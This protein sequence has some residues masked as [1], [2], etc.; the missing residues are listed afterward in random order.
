MAT[1]KRT[2]RRTAHQQPLSIPP[3]PHVRGLQHVEG[4]FLQVLLRKFDLSRCCSTSLGARLEV[5]IPLTAEAIWSN[6]GK[7]HLQDHLPGR[8]RSN[9]RRIQSELR[10]VLLNRQVGHWTFDESHTKLRFR[11]ASGG[12]L[13]IVYLSGKHYYCLLYREIEPIGWN[14][15]NGGSDSRAELLSPLSTAERELREELLVFDFKNHRRYVFQAGDDDVVESPEFALVRK[16]IG[17]RHRHAR[18]ETME[19][20]PLPLKWIDGPD[21]LSV[22]MGPSEHTT[23]RCFLNINAEDFGIEVDRIAWLGLDED[24]VLMDG[25]PT[26]GAERRLVNAPIGLFDMERVNETLRRGADRG[27]PEFLPDLIYQDL[28]KIDLRDCDDRQKR[29]ALG[30]VIERFLSGLGSALPAEK[31]ERWAK[32]RAKYRL[33]PVSGAIIER[34][35]RNAEEPRGSAGEIRPWRTAKRPDVFVS[36]ASE[37][38]DY[39]TRVADMLRRRRRTPFFS[40]YS[41]RDGNFSKVIDEAIDRCKDMVV[42]GSSARHL[43]K[44]WVEYEWRR[45]HVLSQRARSRKGKL[46][47]YVERG[48]N[49]GLLP[50]PLMLQQATQFDRNKLDEMPAVPL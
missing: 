50:G 31:R 7:E 41:I 25:E 37:D 28:G 17:D 33:C 47:P 42:V 16:L 15:A 40:P 32:F 43:E 11:Y 14:I 10:D 22:R 13:P 39:A 18:L 3:S 21:Q 29:T 44:R 30:E 4:Q 9:L 6:K 34:Y 24:A 35:A 26:E 8:G 5:E 36:H 23:D 1:S 2:P 46:I 45:F 38:V 49:P 19:A 20:W 48:V 27:E 12:V